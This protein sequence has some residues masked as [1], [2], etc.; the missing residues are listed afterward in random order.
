MKK[1]VRLAIS[2]ITIIIL[3]IISI[4]CSKGTNNDESYKYFSVPDKIIFYNKGKTET[5][6]KGSDL[7]HNVLALTDKRFDK[8]IDYYQLVMEMKSLKEME[9]NEQ[10]LEFVYS[11]MEETQY[12]SDPAYSR[13][14]KKL[15]MP[16][17]GR[18]TSCIF[19]DDGG[20]TS[21]GPIA[22]L[23]TADDLIK[24]LNRN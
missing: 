6:K 16:F 4:G 19:F 10:V 23:S 17:T 21:F 22:T 5:I 1:I 3:C 15:I 18:Y 24:V 13:K 9:K 14:Y 7:F 20:D 11:E 2:I 8:K 12:S